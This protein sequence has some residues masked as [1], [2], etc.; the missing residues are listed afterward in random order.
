MGYQ[1]GISGAPKN[2]AGAQVLWP[3]AVPFYE[4]GYEEGQ[5]KADPPWCPVPVPPYD[6][7]TVRP[8]DRS[9]EDRER[10]EKERE[11]EERRREL[12]KEWGE[13]PPGREPGYEPLPDLPEPIVGD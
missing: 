8:D 2:T 10:E 3:S 12:M 11:A 6:G 1:D 13:E 7:P 4:A 9:P 5:K